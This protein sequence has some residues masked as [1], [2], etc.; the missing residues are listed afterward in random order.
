MNA[1]GAIG[2][3]FSPQCHHEPSWLP[4][5]TKVL[6]ALVPTAW[7]AP[8][9]NRRTTT[10]TKTSIQTTAA[11]KGAAS[12]LVL[13]Q[14]MDRQMPRIHRVLVANNPIKAW[15]AVL[16]SMIAGIAVAELRA[17]DVPAS[18]SEPPT[19]A[20]RTIGTLSTGVAVVGVQNP[21][22]RWG[23][24][25]TEA[26]QASCFQRKPVQLEFYQ[27]TAKVIIPTSREKSQIWRYTTE[28]PAVGWVKRTFNDSRWK[29]G[30]GGFG[31]IGTP[32]AVVGTNWNTPDIWL[33]REFT[34]AAAPK[35]CLTLM[36][37]HDDDAEV[38]INGVMAAMLHGYTANYVEIELADAAAA[39]LKPGRNSIAVHCHQIVGGQFIDVGLVVR[40]RGGSQQAAGYDTLDVGEGKA[41]GRSIV[42]HGPKVKLAVEDRWSIEGEVLRLDRS[43]RVS[44]HAPEG[45]LSAIVLP[46]E[47]RLTWPQAKW[48]ARGMITV[49]S[50]MRAMPP[51]EA[52]LITG[53][54][55]SRS[56]S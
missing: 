29:Q 51:S 34:I 37:H 6:L 14:P 55:N 54:G 18:E 56:H 50:T 21:D 40:T 10:M 41:L 39:A 42:V 19:T 36:I 5:F 27:E 46:L 3:P 52:E 1:E 9:K 15:V 16:T 53:P 26:G 31:T 43:V 22:G 38:F 13:S 2:A 35:G 45:F 24:R 49:G 12:L 17:A 48:F 32:G 8:R 4:T 28:H 30:R 33:R 11:K 47:R 25:I 23:L 7:I 20:T 44:G